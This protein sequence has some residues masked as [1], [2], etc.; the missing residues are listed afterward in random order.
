MDTLGALL[1]GIVAEPQEEARWLVLA[2]WLE[3]FDDPRRAE[4]LRLHR[5][6]LATSCE[7][8]AHPERAEWQA[9]AVELLTAG[10][11][12]C[13]PQCVLT[14]SDH[15][16]L[17]GS[18]VP[19]GSFLMGGIVEDSERPVHRVS[20]TS[21]FY[22]GIYPVTGTQWTAVMGTEPGHFKGANQPAER[23]SWDDCR[24]FC[25]KL[26]ARLGGWATVRLPTEAEWEYGCRAGT[27]TAYHFGDVPNT[28]LVN[29][30]GNEV[31]NGSARG[32]YRPYTTIVGSFPPNAWGLYDMHGNVWEWCRDWFGDYSVSE[33]T[34]PQGQSSGDRRVQRGGCYRHSPVFCRAASRNGSTPA[35]RFTNVGFRVCFHLN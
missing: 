31:W 8:S 23:V 10:V 29:Y 34:D 22:L 24:E 35:S 19:P 21:G 25:A 11:R 7:P 15:L 20:L 26:T 3:E 33:Q 18:F 4:L 2:D 5:R 14:L 6:L 28:R 17:T 32:P 1:A 16:T 13:V 12:P 30:N 9:R 27:T